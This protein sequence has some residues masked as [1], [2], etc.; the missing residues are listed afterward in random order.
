MAATPQKLVIDCSA[1]PD[2][3]DREQAVELTSAELADYKAREKAPAAPEPLSF[4]KQLAAALESLPDDASVK[5]A[6][7]ALLG[8][9]K[10]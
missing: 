9:L 7:T 5:D 8:V 1:H 4:E 6:V 2:D 3:P 10:G